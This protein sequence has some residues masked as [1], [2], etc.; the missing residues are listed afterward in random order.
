MHKPTRDEIQTKL[1]LHK[2]WLKNPFDGERANF[3]GM[4]LRYLNLSN[5]S[6]QYALFKN[7]LLYAI[8]FENTNLQYANLQYTNLQYA[9]LKDANLCNSNL[10]NSDLKYAIL[11]N[12][13]L[14]AA[15]LQYVNLQH[16][17]LKDANLKDSDLQGANFYCANIQG[18]ILKNTS[19]N[20]ATVGIH[21]AP[22]GDLIGWGKKNGHIVKLLIPAEAK[23]SCATTRKHR[24]EFA[25][26]LEIEG[27]DEV[28][29]ENKHATTV[30]RVGEIVRCHKWDDDR[31]NECGGGIHFFLTRAE[32]EAWW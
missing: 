12:T 9:N 18:V 4:N 22:E 19:I 15:N 11:E 25:K 20:H 29:V 7:S 10:Y 5:S 32:A 28:V 6:L 14:H 13:S 24:A 31:W 30:Y 23:R 17:N 8:N 21:P 1:E 2:L 26:V 3:S 16:S 27:T